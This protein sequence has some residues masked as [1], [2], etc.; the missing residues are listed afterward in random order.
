MITSNRHPLIV[1]LIVALAFTVT[2][3]HAAPIQVDSRGSVLAALPQPGDSRLSSRG[4]LTL[5]PYDAAKFPI[6]D[7]YDGVAQIESGRSDGAIFLAGRIETLRRYASFASANS[8]ATP[9]L[10]PD[11]VTAVPE[12]PT[13]FAA[14][15]A[16]VAVIFFR[17]DGFLP[18]RRSP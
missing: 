13:W 9:N 15:L 2:F 3:G 1:L 17:F 11:D 4:A 5:L 18:R 12:L 16:L 14:L 10:N 7:I 6:T 8:P